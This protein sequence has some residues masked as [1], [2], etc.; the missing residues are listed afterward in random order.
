MT[1]KI[2]TI[3]IVSI[4][5]LSVTGTVLAAQSSQLISKTKA[6]EIALTAQ[7][8]H[9]EDIDL[10]YM[11]GKLV[12]EVDIEHDGI[13]TE[14][15]MDA[16]TGEV[17]KVKHDNDYKV[18]EDKIETTPAAASKV[19]QSTESATPASNA[20][21]STE[22]ATPASKVSQ[23]TE[24]ATPASKASQTTEVATPASK[25]G[26]STEA[27]TLASNDAKQSITEE[28][29]IEKALQIFNGN[30]TEVKLDKDDGIL[31]YEIEIRNADMEAE[32]EIAAS[33]GKVLSKDFDRVDD[34]DYDL[35]DYYDR[36]DNDDDYRLQ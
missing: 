15:K 30:V 12:Y 32:I 14:I 10:D 7:E 18:Y 24:V 1:K 8:G 21:Q 28:Q 34:D 31:V 11:Q 27:A 25:A 16:M 17:L 9:V 13:E 35:D 20:S 29:A 36:D 4:A 22:A 33:S 19:G 26:Q 2:W 3:T 6:K 23:S 5:A